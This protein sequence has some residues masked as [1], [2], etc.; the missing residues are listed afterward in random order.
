MVEILA[1]AFGIMYTPGPANLLS[2]NAGLNGHLRSTIAFCLGVAS[3]MLLLFILFGYTGAWLVGPRYQLLIS[4][5]G[6]MYIMYLAYKIGWASIRTPVA[7]AV[8]QTSTHRLNYKAGLIMQLL[9]PKAFVAILPIVTVQFPEAQISGEAIIVWSLL[10]SC[11]AFG[12]PA[13]YLLMGAHLGKRIREPRY[14]RVLNLCMAA[15]L[16]YV[17]GDIAYNH[18]YLKWG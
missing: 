10:L 13:S 8:E 7:E 6:S 3:A 16:L 5:L 15:L 1:Y 2:M 11:M 12:A 17:A 18:V 14:F 9:N 4:C